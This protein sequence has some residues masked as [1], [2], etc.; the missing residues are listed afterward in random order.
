MASLYEL[1]S[2]YQALLDAYDA[3]ETDDERADIIDA[4]I[5]AKGDITQ[6]GEDYARIIRNVESDVKAYQDEINRM[7]GHVRAGKNLIERLKGNYLDAI[8][9]TGEKEIKT[10]IGKWRIQ[11]NPWSCDVEDWEKVPVKYRTPQPDK[12]DKKSLL[13]DFKATGEIIEGVT[14]KQEMGIRFR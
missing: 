6:K 7:T 9:L 2:A 11:N 10:S 1:T 12:V 3:A 13:D 5:D 4:I 14:F 8:K